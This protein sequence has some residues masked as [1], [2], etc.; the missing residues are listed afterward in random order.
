MRATKAALTGVVS[1]KV[2]EVILRSQ[3]LLLRFKKGCKLYT[4]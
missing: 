4:V 3:I 2:T 1:A